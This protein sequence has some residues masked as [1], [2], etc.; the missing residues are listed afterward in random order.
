MF[1]VR[2]S[3]ILRYVAFSFMAGTLIERWD[4]IGLGS[5][6]GILYLLT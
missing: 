1:A 2:M 4:G 6:T 3:C 5:L